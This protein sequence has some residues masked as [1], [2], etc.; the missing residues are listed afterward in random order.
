MVEKSDKFLTNGCWI[1]KFSYQSFALTKFWY[2]IFYGYNLLTWVCI[3]V[4][5]FMLRHKTLKYFRP[6][7]S[8]KHSP[9]D[10]DPREWKELPILT[11]P[12]LSKVIPSLSSSIGSC[13]AEV[14]KEL[15]GIKW[16]FAKNC[17]AKLTPAQRHETGKLSTLTSTL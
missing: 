13:N 10:K 7:T 15:K 3:R 5:H 9:E 6:I 8:K 17:Y 1:V 14:T 2:C 12:H 11:G 16:F 4:C